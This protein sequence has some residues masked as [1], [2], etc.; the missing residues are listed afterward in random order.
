M[1]FFKKDVRYMQCLSASL[2][3]CVSEPLGGLSKSAIAIVSDYGAFNKPEYAAFRKLMRLYFKQALV[4]RAF[5]GLKP[6]KKI[7]D[8][9]Y[10]LP[11]LETYLSKLQAFILSGNEAKAKR[12]STFL[13][14]FPAAYYRND[15]E[16]MKNILYY[17][18]LRF[19]E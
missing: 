19:L 8:Y 17:E 9:Q 18:P 3:I 6:L 13:V 16:A 12:M 4:D 15:S 14:D 5:K 10:Y 11:K 2:R 1:L 7:D